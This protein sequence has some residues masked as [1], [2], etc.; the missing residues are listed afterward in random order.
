M[1]HNIRQHDQRTGHRFSAPVPREL[2]HRRAISEVF[3]TGIQRNESTIY[4]VSAQWPRWHVFFGSIG[5]GFD[6]ALVVETLRQ[7]T[8][9][10]AHTQLHVPLG[11]QFLMPD[12][13]VSMTSGAMRNPFAPA[14]VTA[15]VM[16]SE[17]KASVQGVNAFRTSAI[18]RVDGQMIADGAAGARIVDPEAYVRIRSRSPVADRHRIVPPVP[19]AD[20]GHS[21]AW[22]VVLGESSAAGCWPLRVDVSNPIL[23]DHPLDHI[24]GVLLIEAVRQS[25][26]LALLDPSLDFSLLEARFMSIAEFGD[27]AVVVLESVTADTDTTT[28]LA[29]IQASGTVRMHATASITTNQQPD[30]VLPPSPRRKPAETGYV[31]LR[32]NLHA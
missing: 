16:V 3:L 10:I 8:V 4:T 19:A 27:E 7:L 21:T 28:V 2:V 29:N 1:T 5:Q 6:S 23:F 12:I 9:L 15:E 20:V 18:F 31:D 17:V 26:R 14:E 30:S 32:E 11:M 24:P 22:N 25:V 13:S